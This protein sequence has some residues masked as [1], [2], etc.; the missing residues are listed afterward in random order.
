LFHGIK[1]EGAAK[2]KKFSFTWKLYLQQK[3]F[4]TRYQA[5]CSSS[6]EQGRGER[7]RIKR[8]LHL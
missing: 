8:E 3:D 6:E 5:E 4:L 7:K 1:E 2:A